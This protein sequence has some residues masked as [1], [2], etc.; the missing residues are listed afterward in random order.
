MPCHMLVERRA[1][2]QANE[3]EI[4]QFGESD[5]TSTGEPMARRNGQYQ[6]VRAKRMAFEARH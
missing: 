4:Q 1:A 6:P 3:I 2:R 5:L